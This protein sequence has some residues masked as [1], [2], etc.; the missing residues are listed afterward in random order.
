VI[1]ARHPALV[2][3]AR[4][5][6][7]QP[8]D[9][10]FAAKIAAALAPAAQLAVDELQWQGRALGS[11]SGTLF[12]RGRSLESND[13]A[14]VGAGGETH[15]SA[16]CAQQ[17]GCN[18]DFTLD[19]HD[20][21]AALGA[22]GFARDVTASQ[23]HFSGDLRWLP[24]AREP[25]ATLS[26][27]LH[28]HLADGIMGLAAEGGMP[29]ALL[30]VPA[31]LAGMSPAPAQGEQSP[32]RFSRL[33]ADYELRD[34]QAVTPALHFDGDAEI[35]VRGRVGLD[36]GDYDEQ[37][38][39]LRGEE[40][41]PAAMRRLGATPRVAALWLAL[42]DLFGNEAADHARTALHLRGPWSNPIV[43]PME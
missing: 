27:S 42:R 22:F 10:A 37:A 23:A 9:A 35:L 17:S 7:M 14:L 4:F 21:A 8:A 15:A 31:L 40:R 12:V 39:I 25:L 29:F 33:S 43:T 28:M 16:R 6:I 24:A 19:S 5:N 18:L 34:G 3:V 11:F 26:G 30:S 13:L 1:D 20:A 2:H 32:L 41:L 36:S 38:W